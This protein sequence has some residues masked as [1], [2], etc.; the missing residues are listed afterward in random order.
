MIRLTKL[1]K[2]WRSHPS[3]LKFPNDEFYRGDLVTCGDPTIINSLTRWDRLVKQDYPIIFHGVQGKDEREAS[4]PSFFNIAEA[5][6]VKK[7]IKDLFEDRKLR[8]SE[9]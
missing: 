6:E 9:C 4:S 8:L 2:N 3:I 1:V 5:S 7:Y